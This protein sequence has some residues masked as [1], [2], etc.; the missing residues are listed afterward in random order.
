MERL[1][2]L[3][4]REKQVLDLVMASKVNKAIA[5]ELEISRSTVEVHKANIMKKTKAGSLA[6]LVSLT[7]MARKNI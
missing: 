3:S 4:D 2:Q 1:Q 5:E 6:E 7:N